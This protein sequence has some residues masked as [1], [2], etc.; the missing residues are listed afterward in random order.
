MLKFLVDHNIP[1][2]VSGWLIA[3]TYDVKLVKDI[4]PEMS[5][6]SVADIAIRE[7]RILL[8][9]DSDFVGLYAREGKGDC[10]IFSL[11]SQG[12]DLRI[13][14]LERILPDMKEGKSFGLLILK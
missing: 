2:S 8:T 9:N 10:I 6:R 13:K 12:S 5:D 1:K 14:A 7:E 4:N 3:R 11:E